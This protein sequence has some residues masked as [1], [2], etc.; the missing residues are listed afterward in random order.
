MS[1]TDS[2][3]CTTVWLARHGEV[4]N[5]NNVLYGR[6]PRVGLTAEGR[7][8]AQALAD[9]LRPRPLVAIYSSPMLRARRTADAVLA[10]HPEL[11]RVRQDSDLIEVRTAWEGEPVEALE[12]I[13]WDFYSHPRHPDDDTLH[14][15]H[16]RMQRWLG[17]VLRRHAGHEVLG[18]SH[19]DPILI[20]VGTL[21]G[22]ALD[23]RTIFP[24][25]YIEP[26][27]LYR[28]CFDAAGRF[29]DATL[30]VP[31]AQAAA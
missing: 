28:L 16:D 7:R 25:P 21:A 9:T 29:E 27:V 24:K 5:P 4:H 17:R 10:V 6:L 18:V 19:G 12:Q 30:L 13:D 23:P 3:R 14:A 11:G 15:I 1:S 26:G 8:Q 2:S 31:H 22:L 20:L